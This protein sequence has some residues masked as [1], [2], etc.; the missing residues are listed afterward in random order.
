MQILESPGWVGLEGPRNLRVNKHLLPD[1]WT[2]LRNTAANR[3][4][5]HR[6]LS[7]PTWEEPTG[8][9]LKPTWV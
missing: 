5:Q 4:T 7:T 6:A 9:S 1:C 2:T 3:Q 8:C